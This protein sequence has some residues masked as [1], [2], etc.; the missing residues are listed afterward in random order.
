[1]YTGKDGKGARESLKEEMRKKYWERQKKKDYYERWH[2]KQEKKDSK[3]N[4]MKRIIKRVRSTG[5]KDKN[6]TER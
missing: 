1:M 6:V 2:I 5:K 3:G 4:N